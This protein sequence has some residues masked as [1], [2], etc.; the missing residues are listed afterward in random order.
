VEDRLARGGFFNQSLR[1]TRGHLVRAVLEGVAYNSRWL[2]SFVEP[3]VGRKLESIRMIGGGAR[4][5]L[6]C[7]IYADVFGRTIQQ[8]D[9][10]VLANA[11]GAA[12][13]AAVALGHLTVDEIPSL[14]PVARTYEP[15]PKNRAIYDELFREFLHL[16]KTSKSVFGR[17]NRTRTAV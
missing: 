9:E 5:K 14:V 13:Q 17:L 4:S 12:F 16:Y 10:P 8:V 1:T 15:D 6:W 2:L 11:R 3:F 7:Q